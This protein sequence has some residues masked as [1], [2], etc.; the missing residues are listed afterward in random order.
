VFLIDVVAGWRSRRRAARDAVGAQRT[1]VW[2]LNALTGIPSS[3]AA[4]QL[5]GGPAAQLCLLDH[6][7]LDR[8]RTLSGVA[9]LLEL[10]RSGRVDF[11]NKTL[12]LAAMGLHPIA[13]ELF[14]LLGAFGTHHVFFG[15]WNGLHEVVQLAEAIAE[16]RLANLYYLP[17][18]TRLKRV[19]MRHV[20]RRPNTRV[21]V[22]LGGDDDLD[23]IRAVIAANSRMQFFV[24]TVAWQKPGSEKRYIDVAIDAANVTPVDC[25]IVQRDSQPV[26]SPAY[27]G[28]YDSCDVVL[29]ATRGDKMFQMRGGVR[30]ADALYARKYLV[31]AENPMCQLLMAQ[32]ERTCLVFEHDPAQA[33]EQLR[34]VVGGGFRID[35]NVYEEIRRVTDAEGQLRWMI[36]AALR[37]DAARESPLARPAPLD[38]APQSLF[39]RGREF[40]A[41]EVNARQV[42]LAAAAAAPRVD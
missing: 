22:S 33:S 24:P 30:V 23:L 25:S 15:L 26:F 21:F 10:H 3:Y 9:E 40:L 2:D 13:N 28:A 34:R 31:M 16:A 5:S 41:R 4:P 39:P 29:I 8:G 11:S 18:A 32:H 14:R 38:I 7:Y 37:P 20:P 12:L 42:M 17:V 6:S 27:A 35:R 19:R 1:P 36:G